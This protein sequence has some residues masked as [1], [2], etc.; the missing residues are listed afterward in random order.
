MEIDGPL[1]GDLF[2]E[3][4]GRAVGEAD[5]LAVRVSETDGTPVQH[6]THTELAVQR[7]ELTPE[8]A[9]AWMREDLARRWTSPPPTG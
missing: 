7:L 3:A 8:Q 6:V 1:D 4:L 2:A 9:E 5:T